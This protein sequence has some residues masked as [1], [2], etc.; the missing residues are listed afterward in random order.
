MTQERAMIRPPHSPFSGPPTRPYALKLQRRNRSRIG[1]QG[2]GIERYRD[3]VPRSARFVL[4]SF[5]SETEERGSSG[6][7]VAGAIDRCQEEIPSTNQTP[8]TL[9]NVTVS[10]SPNSE[11]T[12]LALSP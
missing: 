9:R 11:T 12:A 5:G 7:G 1:G 8:S 3:G 2:T 6:E 10:P 4:G